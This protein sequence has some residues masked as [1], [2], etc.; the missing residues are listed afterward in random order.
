M[1]LN[2]LWNLSGNHQGSGEEWVQH[3]NTDWES[4][5]GVSSAILNTSKSSEIVRIEKS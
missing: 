5:E 4:S 2:G 1:I 3:T